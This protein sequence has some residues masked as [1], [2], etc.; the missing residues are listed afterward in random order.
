MRFAMYGSKFSR[1]CLYIFLLL[2]LQ[3]V[4]LVPFSSGDAEDEEEDIPGTNEEFNRFIK[5]KTKTF[6]TC[7]ISV[8]QR[9][10]CNLDFGK[11]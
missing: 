10:F 3:R 11:L 5:N 4:A 2:A 1:I 6:C 9:R 8:L 7:G